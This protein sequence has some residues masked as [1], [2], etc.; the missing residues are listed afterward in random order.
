MN[1]ER[2]AR[3]RHNT[4][5]FWLNDEEKQLVEARIEVSG[6]PKGDFYRAAVLGEEINSQIVDKE[7]E[8]AAHEKKIDTLLAAERPVK[9]ELALIR[10]DTKQLPAIL[11]GE[12]YFKISE[13]NLNKLMEMAQGAGTLKNLT[14]AYEKEIS[15]MKKTI[16]RLSA[17]VKTLR[18]KV[19]QYETFLD[20]RGL[21]D[22]FVEYIRPKT[23]Q[24]QLA[25]KKAIV[26]KEKGRRM[27][28]V[29][30]KKKHDIAI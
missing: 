16:D 6:M 28:E 20:L 27:Q 17:Q 1:E 14:M 9:R 2:L 15:A 22:A 30:V 11:G 29:D 24:E 21:M 12:P 26:E 8:Y 5:A 4:I 19:K 25:E 10:Q 3:E 7:K 18:S 13:R 23:V